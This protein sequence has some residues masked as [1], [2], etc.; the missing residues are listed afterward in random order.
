MEYIS[1]CCS[2]TFSCQGV[3]GVNSQLFHHRSLVSAHHLHLPLAEWILSSFTGF[4]GTAI[5]LCEMHSGLFNGMCA[6]PW[7]AS[8]PHKAFLTVSMEEAQSSPMHR[9]CDLPAQKETEMVQLVS[10]IF[11]A[12]I[13]LLLDPSVFSDSLSSQEVS[14]ER[15]FQTWGQILQLWET[16]RRKI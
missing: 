16:G 7:A 6:P 3:A 12:W 13:C 10:V 1:I 8:C 4:W 2:V 11:S 15:R 9:I 14:P 5:N